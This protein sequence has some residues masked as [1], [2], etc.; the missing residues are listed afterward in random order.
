MSEQKKYGISPERRD[1]AL[2]YLAETD[3]P[4]GQLK[5]DL[6]RTKYKANAI[7]DAGFLRIE[8]GSVAER[9]AKARGQRE[10]GEAMD[11][12][13][14]LLE[15]YEK[16][17]HKRGTEILVIEVWRTEAADRRAGNV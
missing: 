4:I 10:F 1:K 12:Y 16:I 17:K 14:H 7:E 9:Q 11:H 2:T 8:G 5:S 15:Q 3:E 6:E 13:F